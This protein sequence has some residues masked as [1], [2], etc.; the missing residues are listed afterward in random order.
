[1]KLAMDRCSLFMFTAIRMKIVA[2]DMRMV[3]K[4]IVSM[5]YVPCSVR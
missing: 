1:M 5:V 3:H 2:T 4:M